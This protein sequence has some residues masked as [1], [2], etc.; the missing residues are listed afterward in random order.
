LS[1]RNGQ[2]DQISLPID[3][4]ILDNTFCDP[5]F[6]FSNEVQVTQMIEN[7]IDETR[8]EKDYTYVFCTDTLGKEDIFIHLAK[9]Y[10]TKII[11]STQ[12]FKNMLMIEKSPELFTTDPT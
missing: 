2:N 5:E 11:V 1:Q 4:V 9:K 12:R 8:P 7:L 10:N 3:E 6:S